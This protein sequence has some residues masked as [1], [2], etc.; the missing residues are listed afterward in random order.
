[1]RGD[2]FTG[3]KPRLYPAAGCAVTAWGDCA[4]NRDRTGGLKGEREKQ[5][6]RKG[7]ISIILVLVSLAT[8]VAVAPATASEYPGSVT[9]LAGGQDGDEQ[10]SA[11]QAPYIGSVTALA[12]GHDGSSQPSSPERPYPGSVTALAGGHDGNSQPSSGS[13]QRPVISPSPRSDFQ[14]LNGILGEDGVT[15]AVP[16]ASVAT[17]D[18]FDWTDALIGALISFAVLLMAFLAARSVA[19]RRASTAESRA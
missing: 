11:P 19:R 7:S 17:G 6:T 3:A 13:D 15:Q 9:A 10:V 4:P 16:T 5:M 1:M 18:G 2:V 14:P 8:A 12:A